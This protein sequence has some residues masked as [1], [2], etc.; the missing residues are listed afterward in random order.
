MTQQQLDELWQ[1]AKES[2]NAD[3][4]I[5]GV[6]ATVLDDS[7]NKQQLQVILG[8]YC[9]EFLPEGMAICARGDLMSADDKELLTLHGRVLAAQMLLLLDTHSMNALRDQM[10]MFMEYAS[11]VVRSDYDLIGKVV[12][13]LAYNFLELGYDWSIVENATSLDVLAYRI[14]S[15]S[16]MAKSQPNK[17]EVNGAG[18]VC[19]D[20]GVL[21]VKSSTGP[22]TSAKAFEVAK[23]R[24][25]I[26]T[27]NIRTERLKASCVNE[28]DKLDEFSSVFKATQTETAKNA[29]AGT[30]R[31]IRVGDKVTIKIL[32]IETDDEGYPVV[33]C[34]ALESKDMAEGV[35]QNEEL[36]KGTYT[37]DLAD[38]F[39]E[40][41]CI[42]NAIVVESGE[43]PVF[44]IKKAYHDF[45]AAKAGA[46]DRNLA[47]FEA[48]ALDI[49]EDFDRIFWMTAGG[50]GA[51]SFGIEGVRKGDTAVLCVQNIQTKGDAIYINVC[52]PRYGYDKI[53]RK[54]DEESVLIDF[55][56]PVERAVDNIKRAGTEA[57]KNEK[58]NGVVLSLSR[59][60]ERSA[61]SQKEALE[62]YRRLLCAG[63]LSRLA[64]D[65]RGE[66]N[67]AAKAIF[68]GS[69]IEYAQKGA[70]TRRNA[71]PE[72]SEEQ[73]TILEILG[74]ADSPQKMPEL[75]L[76][77]SQKGKI[78]E[79]A[80][81]ILQ[82]LAALDISYKFKDEIRT[83]SDTVRKA[84]CSI[85][86]VVDQFRESEAVT[87]GK[88]GKGESGKLEFKSSYVMR[89]DHK[90]P[91]I[92]YQGRGQV[93]EAVCAFLNTDGGTVYVGVN[94]KT[95]EPI[96]SEEYG[97]NGDIKW[98]TAN[99]S[100]IDSIR[101]RLL[102][103]HVPKADNLDHFVLFLN[104]E[105]ELYFKESVRKNIRIE[106]TDDQD[107]IRITV[108]P[109]LYE[110]AFLYK[111]NS[112]TE[113]QAFMRDGG[114][115]LPMT[116]RDMEQRLM[117]LKSIKK[118]M[119]FIVTLQESIDKKHKVILR[120]Y[121][122]GNSGK[123]RDRFVVPVNLFYNDENVYCWD[124]EEA[125]FRQFRLARIGSIDTDIENPVY[126]HAFEPKQ[127]DV[128]RW[129]N[130]G[131]DYHIKVR[132]EVGARNYL[133][134]EY[135]DAKNLP[136]TE[137]YEESDGKWI[138][139]THLHG[140]GA[141]RRFYLGLAD[142]I[143][144]LPT[145]DSEKL[146]ED[147]KNY[148]SANFGEYI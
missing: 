93:F 24:I 4:F 18:Q 132:M 78:G 146:K 102:G 77:L 13:T 31:D 131:Q 81:K 41:D 137:L 37:E 51:I 46:D 33:K 69:C 98:L 16:R 100:A 62:S 104:A 143:E 54:F 19:L 43:N 72:L 125:A 61:A 14:C 55:V 10:I 88:Y 58:S 23:G 25:Q 71:L 20:A 45:A 7:I 79:E 68:L 17:F 44:S 27:P 53:D 50:Y 6:W 140:L 124:L 110:I 83:D 21:Q 138:L 3:E 28:A 147:L 106:A 90:G 99:Y 109:S 96:I 129:I 121:A 30:A 85:L 107:A 113:G 145:E 47:F 75:Y 9:E 86:G 135:S 95:G 59:I 128:F 119:E 38:F 105:K 74:A 92:D 64:E 142:K 34:A 111:D 122:S 52:P 97:L 60:L 5:K 89:N 70:L 73:N 134:E 123:I 11:F 36:I 66:A 114:S 87:L 141:I 148:I 116:R 139:D 127:A 29:N 103:H 108:T 39:F 8:R 2:K 32:N 82:L 63:F 115:T 126:S 40:G 67:I 35:V 76:T 94:D 117:S 15:Q 91:D 112:Y 80:G 48:K 22:D 144:L 12:D 1:Q 42:E 118:E 84:I 133:L 26:L 136:A 56:V 57:I 49:R 65:S 130:D 120:N 101:V